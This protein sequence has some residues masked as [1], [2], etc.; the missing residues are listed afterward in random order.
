MIQWENILVEKQQADLVY[1]FVTKIFSSQAV[2]LNTSIS[3]MC[4]PSLCP[5]PF[6][7][8]W[9]IYFKGRVFFLP[10][11]TAYLI[12][13]LHALLGLRELNHIVSRII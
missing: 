13:L 2:S 12:S 9:I 11:E 3:N 10:M 1:S 7:F 8:S 6:F 4:I 5:A